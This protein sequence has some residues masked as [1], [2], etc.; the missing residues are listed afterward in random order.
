[1]T[2]PATEARVLSG[3]L[4]RVAAAKEPPSI[5]VPAK[6]LATET[7][8]DVV[9]GI[10]AKHPWPSDWEARLRAL[11]PISEEHSWLYGA[12]LNIAGR[13]TLYECV[14]YKMI[15]E[16]KRVQLGGTPYWEMPKHLRAGRKQAVSAFQWE[17]YRTKKVWARPFWVIQGNDGGTPAQ[18][19][20]LEE[21][22][23]QA[24]GKDTEP[25]EA[26]S[27]PYAPWDG[28][29]EKQII[30][31][32]RLIKMRQRLDK[33][34]AT[35]DNDALKAET[36]LAEEAFRKE[37]WGWW[38]QTMEPQADFWAWYTNKEESQHL[39]IRQASRAEQAAA[40][41]T[42]ETFLTTGNL[43]VVL[44]WEKTD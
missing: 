4:D 32:D 15:P 17:M 30:S 33:L 25:P 31:R 39:P 7:P 28:R 5:W 19:T 20:E 26:G 9:R 40:E 35:A 1:M 13:W 34:R 41:R 3:L 12:W 24:Q 43:P 6:A 22:I 38:T 16:G 42:E 11:S 36:V 14:P 29:V 21:A 18:Y 2:N 8:L 23:L 27:L 10:A 37:F 44:P